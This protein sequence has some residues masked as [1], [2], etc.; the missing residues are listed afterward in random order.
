MKGIKLYKFHRNK[1]G[2]EQLCDAMEF[3]YIK[4][5]IERFPT[6]RE[7]FYCVILVE[8]GATRVKINGVERVVGPADIVCG[9]PGDV[10]EWEPDPGIK[11]KVVIF[12]PD[13]LLSAVKD[14]LLLQ[15]PA[16]LNPERRIPF[17]K[18]SEKG[19][20]WIKDIMA[21]MMEEV[22]A[23]V[24]FHDLLRAQ[25][26]HLL[27][28]VEKECR[29]WNPAEAGPPARN[30]ASRFINLVGNELYRHHDV[31]YY[32]DRLCVTANYL[33]KIAHASLGVSAREYIQRRIIAE[34]KT[35]LEITEMNVTQVSYALG[36]ETAN[37]FIRFF[38]KRTGT[39]PG[40]YR[41]GKKVAKPLK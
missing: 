18:T 10:W 35:L 23:P 24:R 39:T 33:N 13:F 5:G 4:P 30:Y 16:F 19:V 14:P 37:Y 7:S 11:G 1:Y 32:A 27:L 41:S 31:D 9:L 38:R 26:W 40:M 3:D 28:L 20:L 12:E 8:E 17:I 34:A 15:R 2:V 36:F 21:E 6:H 22:T 29:Q 25:L